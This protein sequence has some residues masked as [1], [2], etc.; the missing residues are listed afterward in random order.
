MTHVQETA[1]IATI[2]TKQKLNNAWT[3]YFHDPD[4]T[5]WTI[6]SY[7]KLAQFATVEEFATVVLTLTDL[8]DRGMY[9]IMRAGIQPIWEDEHNK[10]G[11]CFSMKV[12][13]NHINAVWV[14]TCFQTLGE[15]LVKDKALWAIV[16]G[17]SISPKKNFC[18]VRIW[19]NST[20][21]KEVSI[22]DLNNP[23]YTEIFFKAHTA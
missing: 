7:H 19:I 17:I 4:D 2:A 1:T 6:E 16:T 23:D 18:I 8:W 3:L 15:R 9:F 5:R 10:S 22:Y 11:G 20:V 14:Q 13:K 21:Y 12:M